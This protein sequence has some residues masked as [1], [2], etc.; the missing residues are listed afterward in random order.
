VPTR[1]GIDSLDFDFDNYRTDRIHSLRATPEGG[2]LVGR[3][4][5]TGFVPGFPVAFVV[6][7]LIDLYGCLRGCWEALACGLLK[8]CVQ[9]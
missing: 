5:S 1:T 2:R 8:W 6:G 7:F 3:A 4:F 9:A